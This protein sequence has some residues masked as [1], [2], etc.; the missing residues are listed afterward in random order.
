M[1]A[2]IYQSR[3]RQ[4]PEQALQRALV[5]HLSWRAA[6]GVFFFHVPN[7]G[8]RSRTEAAILKSMGTRAGTP[9]LLLC[10]AGQLYCV[11][12]KS[13][14]GRLSPAQVTCHE[15]LR[16][17]GATVAVATSIDQALAVLT[18]WKIIGGGR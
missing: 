2:A 1:T 6:P 16:R 3:R 10:R 8:W 15:E 14:R 7:G 9:D 12:L 4:Q 11:E 18:E 5:E 13:D 17:A